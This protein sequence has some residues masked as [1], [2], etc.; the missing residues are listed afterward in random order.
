MPVKKTKFSFL[1]A[2]H[3]RIGRKGENIACAF[4]KNRFSEILF[5]NYRTSGGEIDIVA[6]DGSILCFV[7]VKTRRSSSRQRPAQ[8]LSSKQKKRIHSAAMDYM[9]EINSQKI[10]FRFDLIEVILSP[11]DVQELRYWENHFVSP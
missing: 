3:L 5:R 1:R 11:W 8:G 7:E 6:R 4:L 9:K 2:E 10:I